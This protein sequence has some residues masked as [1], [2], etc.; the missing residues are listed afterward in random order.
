MSQSILNNIFFIVIGSLL[1]SCVLYLV[2]IFLISVMSPMLM[3]MS[4]SDTAIGSWKSCL[5]DCC[6]SEYMMIAMNI[7]PVE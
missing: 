6:V 7:I 1:S 2:V 5:N 4:I 3:S